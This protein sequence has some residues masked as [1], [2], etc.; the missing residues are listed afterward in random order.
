MINMYTKLEVSARSIASKSVT[1]SN[2]ILSSQPDLFAAVETWHDSTR[3]PDL[4]ACTP[5]GYRAL[6]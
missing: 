1:L 5:S 2:F 4:I 6:Y 3:N